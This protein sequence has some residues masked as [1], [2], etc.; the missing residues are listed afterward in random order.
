MAPFKS[1]GGLSVGKLLGVFRNRDLTL[2]SSERTN[3]WVPPPSEYTQAS[4]GLTYTPGNGYKYHV[5]SYPN[6]DTFTVD[7]VGYGTPTIEVF[8][9]GGGASSNGPYGH[10]GGGGV[11]R[12]GGVA[13]RSGGAPPYLGDRRGR[14]CRGERRDERGDRVGS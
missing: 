6:S 12:L 7:Q 11:R 2:N 10:G 9:V 8:L 1:T 3:R 4:G 13:G 5:F 14:L